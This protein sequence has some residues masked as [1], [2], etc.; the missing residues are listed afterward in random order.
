MDSDRRRRDDGAGR[1][2]CRFTSVP[3]PGRNPHSPE[4]GWLQWD[5]AVIIAIATLLL[6]AAI[7]ASSGRVRWA[8]VGLLLM[9]WPERYRTGNPSVRER[10]MPQYL[11]P[12]CRRT[13]GSPGIAK[14]RPRQR[15]IA[16]CLQR[17]ACAEEHQDRD[18]EAGIASGKVSHHTKEIRR[19]RE[20][21]SGCACSR[22]Q[23]APM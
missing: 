7:A 11:R 1:D 12:Q 22:V 14:R 21:S 8:L 10:I 17:A 23:V 5:W 2:S 20:R 18:P 13:A 16:R 15:R 6:G 9:M 4:F 3:G 19:E